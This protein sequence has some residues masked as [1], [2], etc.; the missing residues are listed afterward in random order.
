M[1]TSPT[2]RYYDSKPSTRPK[3]PPTPAEVRSQAIAKLKRAA[4]LPRNKDGRRP[5][6]STTNQEETDLPQPVE[7]LLNAIVPEPEPES[8][9][10][11][12]LSP[13][14]TTHSFDQLATY[15]NTS[16]QRSTS[17]SSDYHLPAPHGINYMQ[18]NGSTPYGHSPGLNP[19]H[20]A[21]TPDWAAMQLAQSY[22]PSLSPATLSPSPFGSRQHSSRN[23][24]SPLPTLGDLATL[25][26][27]NS[28]A[29]RARAM[30]KLT[31]GRDVSP[32][33]PPVAQDDLTVKPSQAVR[34]QRSGTVGARVFNLPPAAPSVPAQ[35]EAP[36][37]EPVRPRLQRSFTVSST[38]MGEERRSAVGRR[39]VE[40]LAE[41]RAAREKEEAEVRELWEERRAIA[42]QAQE[43]EV[44]QDE[45]TDEASL[46]AVQRHSP[47]EPP[48]ERM[49]PGVSFGHTEMLGIPDRPESRE[50][51]R[52]NGGPFEYESHLR[53]SLSSRTAR[54]ALGIVSDNEGDSVPMAQGSDVEQLD[55]FD[56]ASSIEHHDF[57]HD[58]EPPRAAFATPSR[59]VA[60]SSTS[61]DGTIQGD[62]SPGSDSNQSRDGL[63]SMM[64]VM[65]H[66]SQGGQSNGPKEGSWPSG[67][68]DQGSSDWG[69][70]PRA[71]E[72]ESSHGV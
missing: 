72:G 18:S 33:P 69:T 17:Q 34:L 40:R 36:T 31:G 67:V 11:E 43:A 51:M 13:S 15:G 66:G 26:R 4:S 25:S 9:H 5:L 62:R 29:A 19:S 58:L 35:E 38:N 42:E 70:P 68:E 39:M 21:S 3:S 37:A 30:D 23:T 8:E 49:G 48:A 20:Q 61:T 63:Q 59:H 65:G 16:M 6:P 27:S 41:R 64:F 32:I 54:G 71:L 7:N 2:R 24:P 52:S 53:R 28:Q 12:V 10:E 50:T 1:S 57:A 56:D 55:R 47:A 45:E 60:Q 14:P 22:L 44:A 46:P